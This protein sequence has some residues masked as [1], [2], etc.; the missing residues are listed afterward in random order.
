M[1]IVDYFD[2]ALSLSEAVVPICSGCMKVVEGDKLRSCG[3]CFKTKYCSRACQKRH[4]KIHKKVCK[5]AK[6]LRFNVGDRVRI[7]VGD[8]WDPWKKG[9]IIGL[10]TGN[11]NAL[12]DIMCDDGALHYAHE[13]SDIL[14][15]KLAD[16]ALIICNKDGTPLTPFP[17]P[18][19]PAE[20]RAAE[21]RD[22]ALFKEAPPEDDCPLCGLRY[23]MKSETLYSKCLF[24]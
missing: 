10:Y 9:I 4:W 12:Y 8:E 15:Q 24:P 13:D 11:K 20:V 14:I 17:K 22:A 23:P 2:S 21:M 7:A 16:E 6:T 1:N 19:S 5:D 18:P 3:A